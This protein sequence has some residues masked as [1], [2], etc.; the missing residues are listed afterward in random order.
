LTG[1]E[2]LPDLFFIERGLLHGNHFA[3]RD[4]KPILIDSGH[5]REY[6]ETLALIA[7]VGVDPSRVG[8]IINTHAHYDHVGADRIIQ[9]RSGCDIALHRIGKH[10]VDAKDHWATWWR[11]YQGP[12]DFSFR[13]NRAL[14]DG[15][16]VAVGPHEFRVVYCP[17]HAAD[18][19]ALYHPQEKILLSSDAL[20]QDDMPA[21]N[22]PVE[23]SRTLFTHLE[24]LDRLA[25]LDIRAVFPGHGPPFTNAPAA[26]TKARQ[27]LETYLTDRTKAGQDL[28]KKLFVYTLLTHGPVEEARFFPRLMIEGWF[29]ET[30]DLDFSGQ[31]REKYLEILQGLVD[32]GLICR[33]G[34][35][36]YTPIKP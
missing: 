31:Y 34:H 8:L 20:F 27:R 2:I 16:I 18:L 14:E 9:D 26:I 22:L 4:R 5:V 32:R 12:E 17:G 36:L 15:E 23:G 13:C 25:S 7:S 30:V 35:R 19:I 33:N 21:L 11:Y 3:Y 6:G 1:L 24:T 29:K 10:F 28:L